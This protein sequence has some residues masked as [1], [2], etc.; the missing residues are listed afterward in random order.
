MAYQMSTIT[1]RFFTK[2]N[3]YLLK[4]DE[5]FVLIDTSFPQRREEVENALRQ[6]GCTPGTLRLIIL[7]HGDPDHTGNAAYLRDT[8]QTS[9]AMHEADVAM[10][11]QADM[12]YGRGASGFARAALKFMSRFMK[13]ESFRPNVLLKERDTLGDYGFPARVIGLPG[14]SPGSIGLLTEE[15]D[16]FCGDLL[17]NFGQ[18]AIHLPVDKAASQASVEK[19]RH[20]EIG[21]VYPGHGKPFEMTA[22][23]AQ[24]K[25]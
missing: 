12:S 14:H 23:F 6:A 25:G 17:N 4:L 7:T 13:A 21:T 15:G 18:P 1:Q 3:C 19:L 22:F 24:W 20:Y 11:E 9:I 2:V 16:L 8:Y 10:V 5:G